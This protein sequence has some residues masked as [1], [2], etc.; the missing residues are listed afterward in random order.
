MAYPLFNASEPVNDRT[1]DAALDFIGN[2]EADGGTEISEALALALNK[3]QV[4]ENGPLRQIIFVTDGAVGNETALMDQ[5]KQGL[6]SARLF[7]VGIGSAPNSYFM[8][9]AAHFGRGT[10]INIAMQDNVMDA[11]AGLFAKN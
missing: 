8:T 10:F 4:N 7:T 3:P 9:E 1:I 11:M 5:I 2:V 6:G